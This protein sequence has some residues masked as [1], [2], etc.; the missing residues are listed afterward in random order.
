MEKIMIENIVKVEFIKNKFDKIDKLIK[1]ENYKDAYIATA[2]LIEIVCMLLISKKFNQ[3]VDNSNIINIIKMLTKNNEKEIVGI[4]KE[5][6]AEYNL[7]NMD[8]V[9]EMD[10]IYLIGYLDEIVK[11]IIEKY[12]NIF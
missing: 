5:I 4:L 7:I 6:N 10:I 2:A 8:N 12:G 3:T 11:E 1:K 9:T